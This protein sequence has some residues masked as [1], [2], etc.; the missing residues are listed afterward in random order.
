MTCSSFN[1]SIISLKI[2]LLLITFVSGCA[3]PRVIEIKPE[4]KASRA[5]VDIAN[6]DAF[7][8][9]RVTVFVKGFYYKDVGDIAAGQTVHIPFDNFVDDNG[10]RFDV[11][12][13]KPEAIRVRAWLD[14]KAASKI[15][16]VK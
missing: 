8:Y 14:G 13:M 15:F 9:P 12:T 11:A 5:G 16:A 10:K 6:R 3:A 7:S 4:V 1:S 2:L